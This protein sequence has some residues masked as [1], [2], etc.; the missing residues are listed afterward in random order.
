MGILSNDI[1]D[2]DLAFDQSKATDIKPYKSGTASDIVLGTVSGTAKGVL[3]VS[4]GISRLVEGDEVGDRRMH[5][6]NEAL[7]PKG[8]GIAGH[9]A[10]GIS[11]VVS[12]GVVG[13]PLG[14][15]GVAGAVGIGT[16]STEHTRL[17][18][19][20]G[21]DQDTADIA[22]NIYGATN[23]VLAGLPIANV[24]RKPL[25]D[26]GATV[27]APTIAG[28]GMTYL[29]GTYLNSKGYEKQGQMY[30]EMATDPTMIAMNLSIGSAFFT[31][32]RL[33]SDPH[34]TQAQVHEAEAK[35]YDAVDQAIANTDLQ[36][37]PTHTN[38]MTDI[39]QHEANINQAVDQIMKGERINISEATGG[40]LKTLQDVRTYIQ[41]NNS[42]NKT[43]KINTDSTTKQSIPSNF[44][45]KSNVSQDHTIRVKDTYHIA[46]QAGFTASQARALVGEL[47]RENGYNLNTMFGTHSDQANK[48]TNK[49]IFSWQGSRLI[50][51]NAHMQA[52]GLVNADGTFK[53]TNEAL[54]EQFI[55]L[56]KEIEANPKWKQSFLDEK[57][58][59]NEEA[60]AALGGKGTII[61]WARGQTKLRS[62]DSFD[63]KAHEVTANKY[64]NM[65][66]GEPT[67]THTVLDESTTE[68]ASIPTKNL[69]S[70]DDTIHRTDLNES[71][72]HV[73]VDDFDLATF[74]S[75]SKIIDEDSLQTIFESMD[76]HQF[77]T[78]PIQS[79]DLLTPH[80]YADISKILDD[81]MDTSV[82]TPVPHTAQGVKVKYD[83]FSSEHQKKFKP[84]DSNTTAWK[85]V[86]RFEEGKYRKEMSR[87]FKDEHGNTVQE[88]KYRGTYLSR[89]IDGAGKTSNIHVGRLNKSDFVNDK[90]NKEL[91]TALNR[92]FDTNNYGYLSQIPKGHEAIAKLEANPN[93][94][95]SSK[96]TGEDLNA[97]QW[98]AKLQREQDNITM[99][100]QAMS[101]LAKCALKNVV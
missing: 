90:G 16:R 74:D 46:Q 39:M 2:Q 86:Q 101:T 62:G 12:A 21:V 42:S 100:T 8:Q 29:E 57:N 53:R 44:N 51:L 36:S 68:H 35:A 26:F 3:S 5:Q 58:I 97:A 4:N 99:M 32:G 55:F 95:I 40:Q 11:E 13:S 81:L 98:K 45:I 93:T 17:T 41:N 85:E 54:K 33:R 20:M 63:W 60:R 70:L 65:V 96:R 82:T 78:A 91:D 38:T 72:P 10:S 76:I 88:L 22:S 31:L 24:F 83:V 67:S 79:K 52:K 50:A 75:R 71:V 28:Q 87:S 47:G 48:L 19:Q 59:S 30:K 64:S 27:I 23:A 61:G 34:A 37:S 14:A 15:L 6:A 92:I 1:T 73:K 25:T 49:G 69:D 9:I 66:D 80:D 18:Q 7:T 56:R 94:V 84:D 77:D 89:T 43:A